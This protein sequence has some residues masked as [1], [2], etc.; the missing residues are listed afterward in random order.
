MAHGGGSTVRHSKIVPHWLKA[1][2]DAHPLVVLAISGTI[3]LG[4]IVALIW[5]IT[6]L[7][8]AH[9][10]GAIAGPAGAAKLQTAREAV[11]TQMLT[12]GAG[13][14]AAGALIFTARSFT[15]SRRTVELNTQGQVT[16][17]YS[18][19]IEQL[20]SDKLDVR[21]GAIYALK[22]IARDSDPDHR[23]VMDVLAAFIREHSREHWPPPEREPNLPSGEASRKKTRPDVQ[24]AID[25]IGHRPG[26]DPEVIDLSGA[27]L[28]GAYLSCVNLVRA[29]LSGAN[30]TDANL[31]GARLTRAI[32]RGAKLNHAH[33]IDAILTGADLADAHL[34]DA[35]LTGADL[36]D[37]YLGGAHLNDA[38]LSSA[39]LRGTNLVGTDLRA[40]CLLDADLSGTAFA[41]VY[42]GGR[43]LSVVTDLTGAFWPDGVPVPAG[44]QRVPGSPT[45]GRVD[46]APRSTP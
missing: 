45:L 9:D 10:V 34:T 41:G 8:A 2:W 21:I 18:R 31:N 30:L 6:D 20:G 13:V 7:I 29:D 5:P 22:R 35:D 16:D 26:M 36:T 15:L 4:I 25:V 19:A 43:G 40:A 23:A 12:L 38:N 3:G 42:V 17:R 11:R 27:D 46:D 39:R 32:V 33:L 1:L 37:A 24:A 44:W 28:T 14:F